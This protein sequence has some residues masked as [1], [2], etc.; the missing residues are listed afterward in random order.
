MEAERGPG[1]RHR[2]REDSEDSKIQARRCTR[3][4]KA[5]SGDRSTGKVPGRG[6]IDEIEP[7]A[8]AVKA[9]PVP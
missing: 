6:C 9:A 4:R 5:A 2:G 3:R 7:R 1:Q 8:G